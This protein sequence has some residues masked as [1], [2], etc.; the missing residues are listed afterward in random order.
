MKS[1]QQRRRPAQAAA[2]RFLRAHL[3]RGH[4]PAGTR[5]PGMIKLA[6]TAGVATGTMVRAV[7]M[8]ASE[9]ALHVS[10]RVGIVSGPRL[11]SSERIM[12]PSAIRHASRVPEAESALIRDVI[13][14]AVVVNG[15][16]PSCKELRI[17]Y[18][19]AFKTVKSILDYLIA[20]GLIQRCRRRYRVM[21]YA[22]P[23]ES[24]SLVL[25]HSPHLWASLLEQSHLRTRVYPFIHALQ[26]QCAERRIR[27]VMKAY[28]GKSRDMPANVAGF[29]VWLGTD[30]D[31]KNNPLVYRL[32]DV[33]WPVVVIDESA[34][35]AFPAALPN[36][37]FLDD[38]NIEAGRRMG[39]FLLDRG[40]RRVCFFSRRA[41]D[42]WG[43]KRCSGIQQV[44]T[45]AGLPEQALRLV[46]ADC[47]TDAKKERVR[48]ARMLDEAVVNERNSAWVVSDDSVALDYLL[49]FL[50]ARKLRP[51]E[52]ISIAGFDNT[53]ESLAQ[54]LASF[55]FDEA[56][57]VPV[58]MSLLLDPAH[59]R[60]LPIN[61][62]HVVSV[63]GFV[64]ARRSVQGM[65]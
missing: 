32:L 40:H 22:P 24:L 52:D 29:I 21:E 7:Q 64:V 30:W 41:T 56:G 1:R 33:G 8:L 42:L 11:P 39:R 43:Q 44:F 27:F 6:R 47:G 50:R 36:L 23:S 45:M 18:G 51:G 61:D 15:F 9:S 63:P 4:W 19:V 12:A 38:C 65:G 26:H 57:S 59:R 48:F 35:D 2:E 14:R 16:L 60:Y 20:Q 28:E 10:S 34:I 55:D 53:M 58:L 3:G 5:L 17:R 25:V 37:Y 46:S 54:N 49:P 13:T 62:A 31:V